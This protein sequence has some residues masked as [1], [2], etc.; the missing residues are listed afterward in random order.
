MGRGIRA[1]T[2]APRIGMIG[3]RPIWLMPVCAG[4][5]KVTLTCEG[6][7]RR[8]RQTDKDTDTDTDT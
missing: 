4:R 5:A 6:V 2:L 7:P 1:E 8:D 3:I